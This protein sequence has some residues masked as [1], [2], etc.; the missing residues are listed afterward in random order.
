MVDLPAVRDHD[1]VLG[2]G[3]VGRVVDDEGEV[4]HAE[5]GGTLEEDEPVLAQHDPFGPTWEFVVDIETEG[6]ANRVGDGDLQFPISVGEQLE[7]VHTVLGV[8]DVDGPISKHS[9]IDEVEVPGLVQL[10]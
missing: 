9:I 5:G 4:V 2:Q 10:Q 8:E 3:D 7:H 1:E 6:L